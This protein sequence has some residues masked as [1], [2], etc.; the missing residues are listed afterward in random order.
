MSSVKTGRTARAA[1]R[2]QRRPYRYA[3][4]LVLSVG[5][6]IALVLLYVDRSVPLKDKL[7]Q[8]GTGLAAAIIFAVI[9]TILAN[10]EYAELIRSE[11]AEQLAEHFNGMLDQIRQLDPLFLP[12]GRYPATKQ[13]DVRFNKDLTS[14]LCNSTFYFFRGTSAKFVPARL[15]MCD[16]RL[17]KVQVILLNPRDT[18]TIEARATDRRKRPEY[19]GKALAEIVD[20]IK[21]ELL[22][23]VVAL[24]DCRDVCNVELGFSG[25]GYDG[26]GLTELERQRQNYKPANVSSTRKQGSRAKWLTCLVTRPLRV[27]AMV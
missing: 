8:I 1:A 6:L 18:G 22:L 2:L 4:A 5:S 10:K 14:D 11:I 13:F 25:S 9:Y 21:D 20:E 26:I 27:S 12:T 24:F 3:L 19:N 16:H 15:R 17:E 23:A 7:T